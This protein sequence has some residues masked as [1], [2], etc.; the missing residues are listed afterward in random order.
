[1]TVSEAIIQWL[2]QFA[3]EKM[4]QID[5]DRMHGDV[6]FALVKEPTI[7]VKKYISGTEVHT[8]YYQMLARLPSLTD[9]DCVENGPWMEELTRWIE[10]MDRERNYPELDNGTVQK[11]GISSSFFVGEN[12][13]ADAIYQMTI[14]IQYIRRNKA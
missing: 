10:K 9:T 12:E 4:R 3:P 6:D 13:D 2:K 8:E 5:T 1:M 14:S 7:N 11:I